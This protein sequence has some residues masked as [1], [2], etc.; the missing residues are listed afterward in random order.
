MWTTLLP[1][2]AATSPVVVDVITRPVSPPPT[3]DVTASNDVLTL[4]SPGKNSK[5][6]IH[7][8]WARFRSLGSRFLGFTLGMARFPGG[9]GVLKPFR[10][11]APP[12]DERV[13]VRAKEL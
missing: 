1:P 6:L 8:R 5:W 10:Q 3:P 2:L 4:S 11:A 7:I 9:I 13:L 12:D